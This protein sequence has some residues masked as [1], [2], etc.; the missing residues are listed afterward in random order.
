MIVSFGDYAICGRADTM[1]KVFLNT[2][3]ICSICEDN[4]DVCVSTLC[5]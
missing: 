3:E 5:C 2:P 1:L 4:T